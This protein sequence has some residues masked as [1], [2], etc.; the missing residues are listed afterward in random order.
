MAIAY[1]R[2]FIYYR[3]GRNCLMSPAM[4]ATQWPWKYYSTVQIPEIYSSAL[5]LLEHHLTIQFP[6][7]LSTVEY[8]S[9]PQT[10]V[11][12]IVY[13]IK[14]RRTVPSNE[15]H[16]MSDLGVTACILRKGAHRTSINLLSK[17]PTLRKGEK[18]F[19]AY[20]VDKGFMGFFFISIPPHSWH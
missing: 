2:K 15:M 16:L 9:H 7:S 11:E 10:K 14:C 8:I 17:F 18:S 20:K 19:G 12:P 13:I 6:C 1:T 5:H 4:L 3:T